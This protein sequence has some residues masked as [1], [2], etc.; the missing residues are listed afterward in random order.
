M[1]NSAVPKTDK[2]ENLSLALNNT[3]AKHKFDG[4]KAHKFTRNNQNLENN[5]QAV[6]FVVYVKASE[7]SALK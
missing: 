4:A 2:S 5:E 3:I 6:Q 1:D 7:V